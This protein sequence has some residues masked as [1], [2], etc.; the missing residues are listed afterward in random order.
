[1]IFPSCYGMSNSN[2]KQAK[3]W[4][5]RQKKTHYKV[6]RIKTHRYSFVLVRM[7]VLAAAAPPNTVSYTASSRQAS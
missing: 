3:S 7:P 4:Q 6:V 5:S 2:G 1:M